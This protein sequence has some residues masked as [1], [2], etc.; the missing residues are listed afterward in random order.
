MQPRKPK[1]QEHFA[2]P[3]VGDPI[4]V[5]NATDLDSRWQLVSQAPGIQVITAPHRVEYPR[6]GGGVINVT[7]SM[8]RDA[9]GYWLEINQLHDSP[10]AA[11]DS[12][13]P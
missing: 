9:D 1:R 5:I 12:K 13:K 4:V 11:G 3:V 2:E 10:A 8:I 6:A 7:M